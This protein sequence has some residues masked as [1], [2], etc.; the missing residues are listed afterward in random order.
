MFKRLSRCILAQLCGHSLIMCLWD[1]D[2]FEEQGMNGVREF[3]SQFLQEDKGAFYTFL[4]DQ[5]IM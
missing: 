4:K 1:T 2:D 5:S 3:I